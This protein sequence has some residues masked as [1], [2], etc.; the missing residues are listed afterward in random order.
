MAEKTAPPLGH[1]Y[2]GRVSPQRLSIARAADAMPGAFSAEDLLRR[3]R[4]DAGGIGAATVYRALAAMAE[5]G[6]VEQ[7]GPRDGAALY[8]RC[9]SGG[10]HH[11]L[12]CTSCGSVAE[13]DCDVAAAV[14]SASRGSGFVVTRHEF[15]LFGLC[16]SCARRGA[17]E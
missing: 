1:A 5:S 3:A 17:A 15:N 14:D 11:H 16:A 12:V 4:A 10:H 7:V 6:F 9:R 2:R 13:A 8:A